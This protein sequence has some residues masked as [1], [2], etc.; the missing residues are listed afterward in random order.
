MKGRANWRRKETRKE[1]GEEEGKGRKYIGAGEE[2]VVNKAHQRTVGEG[3]Q[4]RRKR[5]KEVKRGKE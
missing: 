4:G 2:E 5:R 3:K 1:R